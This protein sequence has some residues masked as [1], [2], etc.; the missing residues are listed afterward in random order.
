M[1]MG[2]AT[3]VYIHTHTLLFAKMMAVIF[4]LPYTVPG[5]RGGTWDKAVSQ[6]GCMRVKSPSYEVGSAAIRSLVNG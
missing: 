6:V 4:N 1:K 2:G 5:C 3:C